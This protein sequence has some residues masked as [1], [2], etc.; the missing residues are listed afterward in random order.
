MLFDR[1]MI[2]ASCAKTILSV[3]F[4]TDL[5]KLGYRIALCVWADS[6]GTEEFRFVYPINSKEKE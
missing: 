4:G 2:S 3:R 1:Y 6:S 5:A